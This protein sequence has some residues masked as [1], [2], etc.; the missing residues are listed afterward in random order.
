MLNESRA[1]YASSGWP[2]ICSLGKVLPFFFFGPLLNMSIVDLRAI[3][4]V[5]RVNENLICCICQTP[6]IDPVT[7]PCGY[8]TTFIH[9]ASKAHS[10]LK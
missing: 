1:I 3:K 2:P 9:T 10:I 8:N 6:F 4:Y 5:E 7:T